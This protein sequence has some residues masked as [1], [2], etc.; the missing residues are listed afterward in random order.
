M[1]TNDWKS[2]L[3]MVY[4][5]NPDFEYN[6]SEDENIEQ[7]A[8]SKQDLRVWLDRKQRGGKV[9]TLVC[10]FRGSESDLKELARTLK[11]K[12]GVGGAAK[13]GEIIIQGD[14][15]DKVVDLLLKAGYKCKKAGG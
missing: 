2:R 14:H 3:G 9:A 15:R 5:T 8:P 10:G 1:S 11:S 7:I 4:S 6:S 13:D 12:C